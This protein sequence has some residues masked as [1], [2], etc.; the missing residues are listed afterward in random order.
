[1]SPAFGDQVIALVAFSVIS[2]FT[3][4]PNNVMLLASGVNFGFRRTI[5]H[6]VGVSFGYPVMAA[7]VA[8]G[9]GGIFR[10]LPWLHTAIE[11]LGVVYL[12]WLAAKIALQ[13]VERELREGDGERRAKP[14][15][16][17]QAAAFQWINAKGW[18]MAISAV[19]IYVPETLGP[20]GG[21]ALLF[22]VNFVTAVG[23]TCA[24]AGLGTGIARW[25]DDPLRLRLFNVTMSLLLVASLWPAFVDLAG[26][27]R[28]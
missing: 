13:P 21:A 25:L 4:G 1:M 11:A 10:T 14:F 15:T 23:S 18:V 22:G 8:L 2:A 6:I 19:T 16:F 28:G 17:L 24:W 7:L 26:W 12:L 5:P 3:P 27:I 20:V 9:L